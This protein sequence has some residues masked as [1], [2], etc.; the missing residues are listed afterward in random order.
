M[1][2]HLFGIIKLLDFMASTLQLALF[3][4]VRSSKDLAR[5]GVRLEKL[6]SSLEVLLIVRLRKNDELVSKSLTEKTFFNL[7]LKKFNLLI[8]GP[9]KLIRYLRPIT[10]QMF[11]ER[12]EK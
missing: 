1:S 3:V 8:S 12:Y 9:R 10:I 6:E 7:V 11:Q 4:L 2:P 5:P